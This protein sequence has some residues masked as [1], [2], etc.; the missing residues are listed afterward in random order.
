MHLSRTSK[1]S[2]ISLG[3]PP[4]SSSSSSSS[5][6]TTITTTT[7]TSPPIPPTGTSSDLAATSAAI[8]RLRSTL[9]TLKKGN[10]NDDNNAASIESLESQI[11]DLRTQEASLKQD[12]DGPSFNRK[13][14]DDTIVRKMFVI[15]SFEIHGGVKGLFDLG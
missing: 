2:V 11:A 7:N 4:S 5:T 3:R 12:I 13:N 14:F 10:N 6:T 9:K 8:T 1:F 15:P